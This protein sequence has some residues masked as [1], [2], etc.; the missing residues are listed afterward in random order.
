MRRA[1]RQEADLALGLKE[2]GE[3]KERLFQEG[4]GRLRRFYWEQ[5]HWAV[6]LG[7]PTL[8]VRA[9]AGVTIEV[10]V[11]EGGRVTCGETRFRGNSLF[12][13][14]RLRTL[15]PYAPGKPCRWGAIEWATQ[16]IRML[17][18]E[19]A[20][21]PRV[22]AGWSRRPGGGADVELLIQEGPPLRLASV[23]VA[24]LRDPVRRAEAE[25]LLVPKPWEL[26]D[27]PKAWATEARLSKL[28]FVQGVR[29]RLKSPGGDNHQVRLIFEVVEG[30]GY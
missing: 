8:R 21:L 7:T 19:K 2:G 17:Y 23:E 27:G 22:T 4:L 15:L 13:D 5:G 24:G 25:K 16:A 29:S 26:F 28:P 20:R 6:D 30:S 10:R 14:E 3:Y 9:D 18:A 12:P 11:R 1:L